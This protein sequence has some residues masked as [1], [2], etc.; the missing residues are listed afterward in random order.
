MPYR[1]EDTLD[2]C[3]GR[4]LKGKSMEQCLVLYSGQAAQLGPLLRVAVTARKASSVVKPRA[5]FKT[6]SRYAIQSSLHAK[7]QKTKLKRA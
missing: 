7:E 2:E 4:L 5:V 6:R 3:V 1:F